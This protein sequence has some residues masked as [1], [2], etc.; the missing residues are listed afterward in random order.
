[1]NKG[2][3]AAGVVAGAAGLAVG[4][5]TVFI[6]AVGSAT[7]ADVVTLNTNQTVTVEIGLDIS[8]LTTEAVA[9]FVGG[10]GSV[11]DLGTASN[12]STV[13]PFT[14]VGV[15]NAVIGDN[16]IGLNVGQNPISFD[17]SVGQRTV[18]ATFELTAG[19]T[20]GDFEY[21]DNVL[22]A[23]QN[24]IAAGQ[25]STFITTPDSV[26]S[27]TFRVVPTPGAAA[28]IGFGGLAAARRRRN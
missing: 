20:L 3:I 23:S 17:T 5:G 11:A 27:D 24:N 12:I 25:F 28:I 10:V 8:G 7:G 15:A 9:N 13:T 1:M 16:G 14:N 22:F 6:N 2:I 21:T 19:S 4:Q 18:V 26:V